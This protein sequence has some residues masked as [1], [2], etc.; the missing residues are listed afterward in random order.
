MVIHR[1]TESII[2]NFYEPPSKPRFQYE[3]WQNG[4]D[5]LVIAKERG[6]DLPVVSV[7]FHPPSKRLPK[8]QMITPPV[9]ARELEPA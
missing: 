1:A 7:Q 4:W 8:Q 2:M 9:R 5:W 3:M 6:G